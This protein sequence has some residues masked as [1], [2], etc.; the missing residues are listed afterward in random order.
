MKRLN[1]IT[2]ILVAVM[3]IVISGC[4]SDMKK[5]PFVIS[6]NTFRDNISVD[7]NSPC[8]NEKIYKTDES[9]RKC[10]D[11]IWGKI[12]GNWSVINL[13]GRRDCGKLPVKVKDCP[14]KDRMDREESYSFT[15][16][17]K[18]GTFKYDTSDKST[19]TKYGYAPIGYKGGA[20]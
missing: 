7:L 9:F 15:I 18:F 13:K 11:N 8:K 17:T 1:K 2:L 6:V 4:G 12:K 16:K 20:K 5:A 14:P 3:G 10:I 19:K